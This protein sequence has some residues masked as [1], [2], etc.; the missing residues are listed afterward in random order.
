[1]SSGVERIRAAFAQAHRESRAAFM[2]YQML[3]HPTL[4]TSPQVIGALADAGADLFE[5]GLPFSDPLADGPTIQAAGQ[6]ALD[7]GVT[8]AY[9]LAAVKELRR[10]IPDKPFCLMGYINPVLAYGPERFVE[11]A[12]RAGVDGLIV[13]DLPPDEPEAEALARLCLDRGIAPIY[14]LA[15]TSTPF[16]IELGVKRSRGFVYLVSVTGITGARDTLNSDLGSFVREVREITDRL[17]VDERPYIAVGFGI[18]NPRLAA[19]VAGIADG[20]IVGSALVELADSSD[21]PPQAVAALGLSL[22]QAAKLP[23]AR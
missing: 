6:Q 19:Q 21:D 23:P 17:P 3:G 8:V 9:C 18:G 16:R 2:P 5:L 14:L 1:M 22:R 20:V 7:N 11:E 4:E 15:P 10:V 13:P 12:S